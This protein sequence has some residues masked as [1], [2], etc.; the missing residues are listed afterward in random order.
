MAYERGRTGADFAAR[1]AAQ[2]Q[3]DDVREFMQ[4]QA[5]REMRTPVAI[6][7]AP[8][9]Y[10]REVMPQAVA[11]TAAASAVQGATRAR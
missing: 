3:R 7:D 4:R 8:T 9:E 11:D 2:R 1:E 6:V 5:E 10:V